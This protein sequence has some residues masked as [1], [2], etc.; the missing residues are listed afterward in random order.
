MCASNLRFSKFAPFALLQI[1]GLCASLNLRPLRFSNL[2]TLRLSNLR[3]LRFYKFAAFAPLSN[4][5]PLRFSNLRTL[6][7]SILRPLRFSNLRPFALVE[8]AP[9]ALLQ[10][11]EIGSLP[12]LW[13]TSLCPLTNTHLCYAFFQICTSSMCASPIGTS[14][15]VL[16]EQ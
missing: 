10:L 13:G 6:R 15:V 14:H 11:C 7:F 5:R 12:G 16:L 8:F 1:C 4:L 3:P 9:F 2:R